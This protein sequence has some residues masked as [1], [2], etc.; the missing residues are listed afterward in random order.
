MQQRA[1]GGNPQQAFTDQLFDLRVLLSE[2]GAPDVTAINQPGGEQPVGRQALMQLRNVIFAVN[3][4]NMQALHRQRG[5][6]IEVRRNAFKIGGQQQFDLAAQRVVS[7]FKGIKPGL[8]QLQHQ[9]RFVNLHPLDAA[10]RQLCQHLLVDRKNIAQQ[11]QAVELLAFHFTQ[12]Q[13]GDRAK[14]H[15]LDVV[16]E[17]QRFIY[18]VQQLGPGEFELLALGEFRHHVVVVG[19]KPFGHFRCCRR[20]AGRRTTTTD[21]EQG[22]DIDRAVFVLMTSRHVAK[23]QAG[24][25]NMVVPGEVADRQQID[26]RFFLL[27]PVTSAQLAAHRQ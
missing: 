3:Q 6:G 14:Q 11:A 10:F 12:P 18:F 17:R 24:G 26:T 20:F 23:Q 9:S 1:G 15:R 2:I 25:Q 21:A 7:R 16:P 22:I 8:R 4:I 19:V 5:N 27:L 13:V